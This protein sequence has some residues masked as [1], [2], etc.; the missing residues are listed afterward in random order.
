VQGCRKWVEG[1]LS[2][3][4]TYPLPADYSTLQPFSSPHRIRNGVL[5]IYV[6]EG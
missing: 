6:E 2:L 5:E 1:L 4:Q 3:F